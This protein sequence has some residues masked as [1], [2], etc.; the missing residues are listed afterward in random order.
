MEGIKSESTIPTWNI[1]DCVV[2][3]NNSIYEITDIRDKVFDNSPGE[4]YVLQSVFNKYLTA[5]VPKDSLLVLKMKP[6]IS[7]ATISSLLE[8]V[9]D[10]PSEWIDDIK[11]RTTK[12]QEIIDDGNRLRILKIF[13]ELNDYKAELEASRKKLYAK[14]NQILSSLEKFITEEYAHVLGKERNSIVSYVFEHTGRHVP[15]I[16]KDI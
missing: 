12:F 3:K 1:G 6:V 5:F 7:A 16:Y 13:L 11:E 10:S 4:Y 8:A 15:E 14:D 9:N 2:F